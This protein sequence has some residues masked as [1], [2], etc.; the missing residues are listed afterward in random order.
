[1]LLIDGASAITKN[2]AQSI[3]GVSTVETLSPQVVTAHFAT[4]LQNIPSKAIKIERRG[5]AKNVPVVV[6]AFAND[7]GPAV[8]DPG[9]TAQSGNA[10]LAQR[11][12]AILIS[13]WRPGR[14]NALCE[15]ITAYSGPDDQ[16]NC[17]RFRMVIEGAGFGRLGPQPRLIP[18]WLM[19]C[20]RFETAM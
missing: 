15:W 12:E 20:V 1:M 9:M 6:E 5:S 3:V 8:T 4:V 2:T 7:P 11:A 18:R 14:E 10:R 17:R 16:A 13:D 19:L